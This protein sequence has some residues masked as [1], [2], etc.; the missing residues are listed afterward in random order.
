MNGNC[1]RGGV[2][3]IEGV[4]PL[5]IEGDFG[6]GICCADAERLEMTSI[7]LRKAWRRERML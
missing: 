3:A 4:A 6:G 2:V 1:Y 5:E 7:F